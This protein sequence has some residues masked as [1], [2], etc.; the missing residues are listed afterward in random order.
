MMLV[1]PVTSD[2]SIDL[3]VKT[4]DECMDELAGLGITGMYAH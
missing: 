3:L 4:W 2:E 1:S